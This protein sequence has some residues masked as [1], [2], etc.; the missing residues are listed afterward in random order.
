MPSSFTMALAFSRHRWHILITLLLL[1][2]VPPSPAAASS[3]TSAPPDDGGELPLHPSSPPHRKAPP[4]QH[5]QQRHFIQ[6]SAGGAR[7]KRQAY[8][9]Y[10]GNDVSV[11]VDRGQK[12]SGPW[13]P[14]TVERECSRTCGGGVYTERRICGGDGHCAG[15]S[16]RYISCNLEPCPADAMDFRAEQCAAHNDDPVAGKYYKW[17]PHTSKNKCE[18]TCRPEGDSF[19]YNWAEKVIDGTKCDA[20]GEEICVDGICLP[21][22]CDGKLGSEAKRDKC[23]VCQGDGSQCKT[24]EGL[25]DERALS[26]GY[27]DIIALPAGATA[28]HIEELRPSSNV[29]AIKNATGF[30]Y[31]NGNFQIQVLDKN[32]LA[33]GVPFKYEKGN[34]GTERLTANGPLQESVTVSLLL[35]RTGAKQSAVKYEYSVPLEK[36]VKYLYKPGEW[37]QCS[38]TCGRGVHTRALYCTETATQLRVD[39]SL[40]DENNATKPEFEKKCT[41]VDCQPEWF[42]GEWEPCSTTCGD[43]G[44]QFRVL[45]CHRVFA[46]GRRMTVSDANCTEERGLPRPDMSQPCARWSCPEWQAG[47]W[48]ACSSQCGDAKQ[49]RSVTC[50]SAKE[51]EE[52][53]MLPAEACTGQMPPEER[54]CNLGPCK[55]L[56]FHTTEWE[57]CQKCNDTEETREVSCV[58]KNGR[59]YP[60]EKCLDGKKVTKIPEDTRPCASQAPCVYEWHTSQWSKCSTECGHGHKQ[61]KV[62]C[63]INELGQTK[64]VDEALCDQSVEEKP[65]AREECVNEE[66][67]TGI[68]FTGPWS[69]CTAKCDGGT[70][71]RTVVCLNYDKKPVPEWCDEKEKPAEQQECGMDKCQNC[72]DSEFGCC[73]DGESFASGP[74]LEGC[75]NCSSVAEFGCCADNVT[76]REDAQGTNCPEAA[77]GKKGVTFDEAEGSGEEPSDAEEAAPPSKEMCEIETVDTKEKLQIPCSEA[78]AVTKTM[79]ETV[80]LIKMASADETAPEAKETNATAEEAAPAEKHC[81]KTEFGCCPDWN[82]PAEGPNYAGCPKF[83]LGN[84]N[85]TKFGC[86]PDEVSMARGPDFEGCGEPTCAAS[87]FGCCKDR[88]TIA[89]GPHYAGCDRSSFPCELSTYGCC[90]DG[91]TAALGPNGTGCGASCLLTK[92]GCCPDG[93]THAKGANNEGCGCEYAQ[94]GCCPDGHNA[95]KGPG[96]YGCPESCAQSK[97]GCCPDGKTIA[98]GP[99]KEGCPCQYTRWGCCPDG[100]TTALGPLN[101]GCDDCRYAKYGCCLDGVSKAIGPEYAGCPTTTPAPYMLGGTVSPSYIVSCSLP[102]DQGQ[103]CHSGY[104]LAWYY[105]MVE[106]SCSQFWYG[107]CGGNNNRFSSKEQCEQICVE[108]PQIGRCYLPRVEGPQRCDQLAARYYYDYLTRQCAAFWWRGCRGNA[109]N[110]GSWEECQSFCSSADASNVEVQQPPYQAASAPAVAAAAPPPPP[111]VQPQDIQAPPPFTHPPQTVAILPAGIEETGELQKA[112]ILDEEACRQNVDSGTCQNYVDQWYFD[113]FTGACFRFIYSGC[114]GNRNRFGTEVECLRQ[115]GHLRKP[116]P[117]FLGPTSA[118]AVPSLN[119]KP[120]V[121]K[122][123]TGR[124]ALTKSRD[125][126]NLRAD[127]GKCIGNFVSWYYEVASGQCEKFKFTG[128]GGNGN[129]FTTLDECQAVCVRRNDL[130]SA[131]AASGPQNMEQHLVAPAPVGAS[132]EKE[133][134]PALPNAHLALMCE[135]PKDSGPCKTFSTKWYYNALDGTCNRFHYGGCDGNANRFDTEEQCK[136]ICWNYKDPCVLPKVSGPCEG[137][138]RRFF[139]DLHTNQCLLFEYGGCLGNSNNFHTMED[140]QARC[141]PT[142]PM[143]IVA[144]TTNPWPIRLTRANPSTPTPAAAAVELLDHRDVDNNNDLLIS[145]NSDQQ[146]PHQLDAADQQSYQQQTADIVG[147]NRSDQQSEWNQNGDQKPSDQSEANDDQQEEVEIEEG[148]EEEEL[149]VVPREHL[150]YGQLPELCLLPEQRGTCFGEQLR[151]RYDASV[152]DCVGFF[153]TGCDANVNNFDSYEACAR[154]CGAWK[155]DAV[156]ERSPDAGR[157]HCD[158]GGGG[159]HGQRVGWRQRDYSNMAGANVPKWYY[160]AALG[161]CGLFFWSGCGGN[162]NR[163]QSKSECENLCRREMLAKTHQKSDMCMLPMDAG[164]C[165]DLVTMWY[166]DA[167][168]QQCRRFTFGG[169]RGNSNRF[170]SRM[171]CESQC[172]NAAAR[173]VSMGNKPVDTADHS[174]S[175]ANQNAK[176]VQQQRGAQTYS[177][178]YHRRRQR[179]R[180]FASPVG[181]LLVGTSSTLTLKCVA[182]GDGGGTEAAAPMTRDDKFTWYKD[183][184][185]MSTLTTDA[186]EQRIKFFQSVQQTH[187][188]AADGGLAVVGELRFRTVTAADAGA[189]ACA[190]GTLIS[191]PVTV[192]VVDQRGKPIENS[193]Q[194]RPIARDSRFSE[195]R[196]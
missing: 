90:E 16:I 5:Q 156:C 120:K 18:L 36:D 72:T 30:F 152:G 179:P 6:Y 184:Q 142:R 41:T 186:E 27:H 46:D 85:G 11:S 100:E 95:A 159:D 82:T 183:N 62:F 69:N 26:S 98:R 194:Q 49:F 15:P 140:C 79:N 67:C 74:F 110:F 161:K 169:C 185:E 71:T 22:G 148:E 113:P 12:D 78:A 68:F 141:R 57:L 160:D 70:Q 9:V 92:F 73:P 86:C 107:G 88:R 10:L 106:G 91:E 158:T 116:K 51:G 143:P 103:V 3:A 154:A 128:C 28:I 122:L 121:E 181:I 188:E 23:G 131:S 87:T 177:M 150:L 196:F 61:R 168:Q 163:F 119:E 124:K 58:D 191:D 17:V 45:Y 50:R 123:S 190:F 105:D 135:V 66:K 146:T 76:A 21:V 138:S 130:P 65:V 29:F 104:Q 153:F 108:P 94:Y 38:V 132:A 137:H 59:E 39:D 176:N 48:S 84:C 187:A 167:A 109:N 34:G 1:L 97:F 52:G 60:L 75:S 139:F 81:S 129:R 102:Q 162:G 7:S 13:G 89:F 166:F 63:A 80:Q 44:V 134:P 55:G 126:C 171:D 144:T 53:K 99:N 2:L 173:N 192:R 43:R 20:Y 136:N 189:Y 101:E 117:G 165:A 40:C 178:T 182:D 147:D 127:P 33:G 170:V 77:A 157:D 172:R 195:S 180:L 83:V 24:V 35:Q 145:S 118:A 164:P 37:S 25:F 125:V 8:Q 96:F 114:G 31:L 151:Y 64:R 175:D 56:R 115:C 42:V 149:I 133:T 174:A 54:D 47:P 32:I 193:K 155:A 93:K 19:Y 111:P 4:A 14:W 112:P